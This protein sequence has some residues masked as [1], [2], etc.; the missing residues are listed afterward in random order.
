MAIDMIGEMLERHNDREVI[1]H[2]ASIMA[3]VLKNYKTAFEQGQPEVLWGNLGDI[4]LVATT[5]RTMK[6]RNDA[7]EAQKEM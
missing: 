5:L 1:D 3:G 4:S 7:R 6:K 2:L